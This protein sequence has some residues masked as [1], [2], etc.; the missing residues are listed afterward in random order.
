MSWD[1]GPAAAE[2][3]VSRTL[4]DAARR[5]ELAYQQAFMEKDPRLAA[6]H[7]RQQELLTRVQTVELQAQRAESRFGKSEALARH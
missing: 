3:L 7:M 6:D 5:Q 2:P 4:L 1:A